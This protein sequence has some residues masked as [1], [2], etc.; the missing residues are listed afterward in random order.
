MSLGV[1]AD[2]VSKWERGVIC[3]NLEQLK[4]LCEILQIPASKLYFGITDTRQTEPP[5]R[6]R[7]KKPI[8]MLVFLQH[9]YFVPEQSSETRRSIIAPVLRA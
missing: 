8:P 2:A 1:S 4:G 3:P 6:I 5:V 7:R 9:Y